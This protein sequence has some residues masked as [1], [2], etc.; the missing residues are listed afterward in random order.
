MSH[1]ADRDSIRGGT[2]TVHLFARENGEHPWRS[3]RRGSG[4]SH[5]LPPSCSAS[6]WSFEK[7]FLYIF[8][9]VLLAD[10]SKQI[11]SMIIS[12]SFVLPGVT[13]LIGPW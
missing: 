1:A 9:D 3:S 7:N 5:F 11:R 2:T 8:V 10:L 4:T 13:F 12:V 6:V